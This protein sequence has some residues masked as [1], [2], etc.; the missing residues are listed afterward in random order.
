[1]QH[2]RIRMVG[3]AMLA[4]ALGAIAAC[5]GGDTSSKADGK[6]FDAGGVEL[7]Y[8]G[9]IGIDEINAGRD[10]YAA[11]KS[12]ERM[13]SMAQKALDD[14]ASAGTSVQ[15]MYKICADAGLKFQGKV[16][17]ESDRLQVLCG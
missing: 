7:I 6:W 10:P 2:L 8:E 14:S 9:Q 11:D 4:A 13:L 1:M 12:C 17:C 15:I 16:R 5:N 3:S